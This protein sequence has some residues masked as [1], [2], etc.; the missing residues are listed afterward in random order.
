[1]STQPVRGRLGLDLRCFP[2]S[3]LAFFLVQVLLVGFLLLAS[4]M[5]L[6]F[7]FF[8]L[9]TEKRVEEINISWVH[10][11]LLLPAAFTRRRPRCSV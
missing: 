8:P 11:P 2:P 7:F 5:Q 10:Q 3:S 1:M 4:V 6:F 9:K